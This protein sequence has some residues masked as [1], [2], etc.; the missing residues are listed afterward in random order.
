MACHRAET[1][2]QGAKSP[3]AAQ[4]K[5]PAEVAFHGSSSRHDDPLSKLSDLP[6]RAIVKGRWAAGSSQGSRAVRGWCSRGRRP[7]RWAEPGPPDSQGTIGSRYRRIRRMRR[8]SDNLA[9]SPYS[10]RKA[11][12][13]NGRP[14]CGSRPGRRTA[15][16]PREQETRVSSGTI[17]FDCVIG[18]ATTGRG[19]P[20]G[21]PRR[22]RRL[23]SPAVEGVTRRGAGSSVLTRPS[24][25]RDRPGNWQSPENRQN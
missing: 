3:G 16:P 17:P 23:A 22:Q 4:E 9:G 11:R 20:P 7:R 19:L 13:E 10:C 1:P 12:T 24:Y 21:R 2:A 15:R 14:G 25:N 8:R 5:Q 6:R 18:F